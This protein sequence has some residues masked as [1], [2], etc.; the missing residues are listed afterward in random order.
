MPTTEELRELWRAELQEEARSRHAGEP[1]PY[2][3][4]ARL[5]WMMAEGEIP[6]IDCDPE[7]TWIWSD[8]H[9]GDETCREVWERPFPS[10]LAMNRHLLAEWRRCVRP[11]DTIICLGDVAHPEFWR[12]RGNILDLRDCPGDRVLILGNHDID[13][14]DELREAGFTQQC[15]AALATTSPRLALSHLPLRWPPVTAWNAHGHTHGADPPGRRHVNVS[16]ERTGFKP[17]RLSEVLTRVRR[18]RD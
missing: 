4:I 10:L 8:L 18:E 3:E 17:Q 2:F 16:V 7:S 1:E 5:A 12:E 14:T 15:A 9:L 13:H 11:T 6:V